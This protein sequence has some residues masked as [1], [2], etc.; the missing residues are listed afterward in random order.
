M[1]MPVGRMV[2]VFGGYPGNL[3]FKSLAELL[4]G[5]FCNVPQVQ[6]PPGILPLGVRT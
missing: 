5:L 1:D 3:F 2:V 4:H 6:I